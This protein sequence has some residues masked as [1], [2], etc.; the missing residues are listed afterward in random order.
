MEC[1]GLNAQL[2]RT[3]D[4]IIGIYWWRKPEVPE[5]TTEQSQVTDKLYHIMLYTLPWST[6]VVIG[7]DFIGS[8]KSNYHTITATTAPTISCVSIKVQFFIPYLSSNR[9]KLY[10]RCNLTQWPKRAPLSEVA[11]TPS[12]ISFP[13]NYILSRHDIQVLALVYLFKK[14]PWDYSIK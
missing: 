13:V 9:S 4:Y 8:C 5:K 11:S 6:S 7:T 10:H 1:C 12:N 14:T 3:K 2:S